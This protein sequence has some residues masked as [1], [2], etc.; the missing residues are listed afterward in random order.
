MH[1][2]LKYYSMFENLFK[3]WSTFNNNNNRD[4]SETKVE[5]YVSLKKEGKKKRINYITQVCWIRLFLERRKL[6]ND[7]V[8]A[9]PLQKNNYEVKGLSVTHL[10]RVVG[11]FIYLPL[12]LRVC[13]FLFTYIP[14]WDTIF[15]VPFH[16][17]PPTRRFVR[18]PNRNRSNFKGT[19]CY[20]IREKPF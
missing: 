2:S 6:A 12:F 16:A 11:I 9:Y 18:R 3:H 5:L 14:P 4:E 20:L 15:K 13:L 19:S 1:C 17:F 7:S 8:S 10:H